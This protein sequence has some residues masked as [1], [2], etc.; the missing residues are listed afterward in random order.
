MAY[1][2]ASKRILEHKCKGDEATLVKNLCTGNYETAAH[3]A[4]N[5]ESLR[6]HIA[7]GFTRELKKEMK[8]YTSKKDNLFS[9]DGNTQKLSEYSTA[10]LLEEAKET[11]PLL[12]TVITGSS[13][14]NKV[15]NLREKEALILSSFLN[16]WIPRSNFAYRNNVLLC[17]GA[18]KGEVIS[19]FQKQGLC[20]HKNTT[21]NM[22]ND[23]SKSFDKDLRKWKDD[24]SSTKKQLHLLKGYMDNQST[25]EDNQMDVSTI[26]FTE[27]EL[28]GS[29]F[30]EEETYQNCQSLL[31][32]N[33]HGTCDVDDIVN[34]INRLEK[35]TP[36]RYR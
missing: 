12:H 23:V 2:G 25:P 19:M 36:A 35:A 5:L 21:R 8:E 13:R 6:S 22:L 24:I 11:M 4:L 10:A 27:E 14:K 28:K 18:C 16:T 34:A 29:K 17:V 20:S 7:E 1:T 15:T 9:Y 30:F 31:P 32:L 3:A 33:E 26:V